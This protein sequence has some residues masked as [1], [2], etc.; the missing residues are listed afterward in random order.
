MI[1]LK[2]VVTV[3]AY[4]Y[5]EDYDLYEIIEGEKIMAAAPS[6]THNTIVTRLLTTFMNYVDEHDCGAVFG[7]NIDVH[8]PDGNLFRPDVSIVCDKNILEQRKAIYGV[9]DLVVEVLSPSTA[10]RDL[11]KKKDIYARN[12]VKE[13]WI[14][15]P[16]D[17]RIEVYHLLDGKFELDGVYYGYSDAMLETLTDDDRAAVQTDI[18]VSLFDDLI[19]DAKKIFKWWFD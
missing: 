4:A 7:D 5:A 13:Y 1:D 6:L 19:V 2:G 12:G 11:T 17:R 18:K 15:S 3:S 8:L 10:K 14:V 16:N 9:P